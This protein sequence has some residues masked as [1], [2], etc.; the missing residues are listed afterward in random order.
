[1]QLKNILIITT[2][3]LFLISFVYT[4]S[5]ITATIGN[6]RMVLRLSP[7]ELVEKSIL[8]R[9]INNVSVEINLTATGDLADSVVLKNP[10]FFL[11]PG[12]EKNADFTIKATKQGMTETKVNVMFTQAEGGGVVLSSNVIVISGNVTETG[13]DT[14]SNS[15]N[16]TSNSSTYQNSSSIQ[17]KTSKSTEKDSSS[18]LWMSIGI[19]LIL[20]IILFVLFIYSKKSGKNDNAEKKEAQIK[21]KKS[22]SKDE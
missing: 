8:V 19:P 15:L 21:L 11:A 12:E 18:G 5:A 10:S 13:S 4:A 7:G 17:N 22:A 3:L 6:S 16:S 2:V 9:N 20:V 14:D 1:M